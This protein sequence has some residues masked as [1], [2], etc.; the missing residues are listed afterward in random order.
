MPA[1]RSRSAGLQPALRAGT[2]TV[3]FEPQR[4]A[5]RSPKADKNVGAPQSGSWGSIRRVNLNE[6]G[7]SLFQLNLFSPAAFH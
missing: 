4:L 3:W 1:L 2:R 5:V 6:G 7:V